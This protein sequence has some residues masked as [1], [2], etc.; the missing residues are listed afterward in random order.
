MPRDDSKKDGTV[1][2]NIEE[3][4]KTRDS[5]LAGLAQ[6]Q[7]AAFELS[8]AY[9]HHTNTVLG[10][11]NPNGDLAAFTNLTASL[12]E[13]GLLGP[14]ASAPGTGDDKR[15]RK[16]AKPDPNAPKRALTP[17][18]LYMKHNRQTIA[19]EL[20]DK[21]ARKEV[22]DEGTR[23]WS[24]M[25]DS[26]KE[27]WKK[28]YADNL[29]TYREQ[30]AAYKAGKSIDHDDEDHDKSAD[31]LQGDVEAAQQSDEESEESEEEEEEESPE[32]VKEPT[33]PPPKRRR[34]EGKP[35]KEASSPVKK[36][37]GKK[38]EPPKPPASETKRN[39]K[40][41]KSEAGGDA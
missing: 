19:K 33:P 16:R 14:I 11:D 13:S 39:K 18:F 22:A 32:P 25:P 9:I 40:K 4:T 34:S 36:R 5:V 17:F 41:R 1:T 23:R 2:V 15:K 8:R 31:Q 20:G 21:A 3:F 35:S 10:Q 12:R 26:Q 7:A 29:A 30:M 28:M 37:G 6:L 27:I 38:E 24:E